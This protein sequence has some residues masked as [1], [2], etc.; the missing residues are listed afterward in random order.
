MYIVVC[1]YVARKFLVIAIL[2]VHHIAIA[3]NVTVITQPDNTTT[4]EGGTAV[5]TCVVDILNVNINT[6]DIRWWRIRLD[7]TSSQPLP[8]TETVTKYTISNSINEHR[9]TSVLMITDVGSE[10][11]G[12]Y[13]PGLIDKK[14]L[15]S[16][17]FLSITL[18]NGTYMCMYHNYVYYV[19]M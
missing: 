2:L 8:V 17:A 5:F 12:P 16:M 7:Q 11:M 1:I 9:V 6:V 14:Q 13:W 18:Q 15:C 10:H 4:C 3:I 19:R